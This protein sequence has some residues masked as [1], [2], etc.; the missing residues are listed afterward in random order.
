MSSVFPN[1]LIITSQWGYIYWDS[2][3]CWI[4]PVCL[5]ICSNYHCTS[6]LIKQTLGRPSSYLH[7]YYSTLYPYR[8]LLNSNSI[9]IPLLSLI[10][11]MPGLPYHSSHLFIPTPFPDRHS[12][13]RDSHPNKDS[14]PAHHQDMRNF[15][16]T[17]STVAETLASPRPCASWCIVCAC[18]CLV[19]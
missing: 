11:R 18:M 4:C 6:T 9:H 10:N 2:S 16:P 7:L 3:A 1:G 19:L 8:T 12:S 5:S 15:T 13:P 14:S 17:S